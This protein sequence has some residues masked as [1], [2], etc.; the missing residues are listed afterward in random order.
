MTRINKIFLCERSDFMC[1][2]VDAEYIV[3]N[4]LL[5]NLEKGKTSVSLI[6]INR[7][8]KK[9]ENLLVPC[10][11]RGSFESI[12]DVTEMYPGLFKIS[13]NSIELVE[14]NTEKCK[15]N[16][17]VYFNN[18]LPKNVIDAFETATI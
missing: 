3:A 2:Y 17:M 5:K 11:V 12:Y 7:Y 8:R 14:E 6:E 1:T 15:H 18:G 16:L 4:A 9:V 10:I 13:K